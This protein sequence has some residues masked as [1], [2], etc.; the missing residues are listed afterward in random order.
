MK[1]GVSRS[2]GLGVVLVAS[3][4]GAGFLGCAV[5]PSPGGQGPELA[6]TAAQPLGGPLP[7][8][9]KLAPNAVYAYPHKPGFD[10]SYAPTKYTVSAFYGGQT[11]AGYM[12]P[13]GTDGDASAGDMVTCG[14]DP[15]AYEQKLWGNVSRANG[16][17]YYVWAQVGQVTGVYMAVG[18][19]ASTAGSSR[20]YEPPSP[21]GNPTGGSPTP[22]DWYSEQQVVASPLG[23]ATDVEAKYIQCARVYAADTGELLDSFP[24]LDLHD[25]HNPPW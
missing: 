6:A 10:F 3:A 19:N 18:V 9:N 7:D 12:M 15:H 16:Y 8:C 23:V 17:A 14:S 21:P 24:L 11:D 4:L 22:S 5:E 1:S 2:R 13:C 25:P 20:E